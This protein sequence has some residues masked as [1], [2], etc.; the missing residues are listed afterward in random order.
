[1]VADDSALV[2]EVAAEAAEVAALDAEVAAEDADVAAAVAD[3][4]VF[5]CNDDSEIHVPVLVSVS[6]IEPISRTRPEAT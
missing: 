5:V 2:A 6:V 1:M 4:W 3:A